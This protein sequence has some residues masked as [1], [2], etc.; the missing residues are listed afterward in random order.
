VGLFLALG[1]KYQQSLLN[2]N[3]AKEAAYYQYL[4]DSVKSKYLSQA[5]KS[6]GLLNDK[7]YE[8]KRVYF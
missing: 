2:E 5:R 8:L 4:F 1:L 3:H 7:R 6:I